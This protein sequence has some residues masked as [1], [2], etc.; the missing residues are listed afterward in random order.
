MKSANGSG[1][2]SS[3]T[4]PRQNEA[5][6]LV[7]MDLVDG[8]R[9]VICMYGSLGSKSDITHE[10]ILECGGLNSTIVTLKHPVPMDRS[11]TRL[12]PLPLQMEGATF[13][14]AKV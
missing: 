12:K 5:V 6:G 7:P 8:N 9:P 2:M 13:E 11:S 1:S 14:R 4:R 10:S 3:P